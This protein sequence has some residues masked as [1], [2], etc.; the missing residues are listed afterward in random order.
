MIFD[1]G[2][3]GGTGDTTGNGTG[4]GGTG[5]TTGNGTGDGG[6]GGTVDALAARLSALPPSVGPVRLVGVDGHAG[7]GKSTL[8]RRLAAALPGTTPVLHLDDLA[9]HDAFF[10]WTDT[11]RSRVVAPLAR[12]EVAHH[13]VYD[14]TRRAFT[15]SAPLEPA[16]VVLVEG[17]GAGRRAV[18][19]HLALLIWLEVPPEV[20][21]RR[22]RLRDGPALAS[23]WDAWERAELRH[24]ADDPSRPFAD[25]LMTSGGDSHHA[26]E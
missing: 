6:T 15:A 21:W 19:P 25:I 11:F 23:F 18:R 17:V 5:D 12:G 24:F 7:S 4:D 16:P 14:W 9:S 10:D 26:C 2:A 8:A 13:P 3:D 1:G 20:A 22:G